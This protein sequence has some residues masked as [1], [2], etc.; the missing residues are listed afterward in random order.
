[1]MIHTCD[2]QTQ[3]VTKTATGGK[4]DG[5]TSKASAI[6]CRIEKLK[7][8]ASALYADRFAPTEMFRVYFDTE[9]NL[10]ETKDQLVIDSKGYQVVAVYNVDR[11]GRLWQVDVVRL[12][13]F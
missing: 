8:D 2:I 1:M 9:N 10:L 4:V 3:A 12:P 13:A 7:P 11:L 5:W 6:P